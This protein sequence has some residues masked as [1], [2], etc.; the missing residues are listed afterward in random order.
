MTRNEVLAISLELEGLTVVLA[1]QITQPCLCKSNPRPQ[2]RIQHPFELLGCG[3][4]EVRRLF[5]GSIAL[6]T[7]RFVGAGERREW[8]VKEG[9]RG[10]IYGSS[11]K[12]KAFGKDICGESIDTERIKL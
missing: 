2:L 9:G 3:I 7:G 12:H 10:G 8:S 5:V 6:V 4:D 11:E 1:D